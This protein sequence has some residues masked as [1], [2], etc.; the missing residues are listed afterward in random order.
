MIFNP[1]LI[2]VYMHKQAAPTHTL[3]LVELFV[4]TDIVLVDQL[5]FP[6]QFGNFGGLSSHR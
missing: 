2:L 4:N 3:C 6:L 5:Q 1:V